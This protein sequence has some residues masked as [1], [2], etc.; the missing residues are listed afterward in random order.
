MQ[1][2]I[3]RND[4]LFCGRPWG[5]LIGYAFYSAGTVREVMGWDDCTR[6]HEQP[7]QCHITDMS[8]GNVVRGWR[9][10]YVRRLW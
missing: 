10:G 5:M 4:T 6:A 9:D 3:T 8:R 1:D 2:P 7:M